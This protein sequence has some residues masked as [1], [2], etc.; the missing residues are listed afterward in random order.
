M[1]SRFSV[2]EEETNKA[3]TKN[4]VAVLVGGALILSVAIGGHAGELRFQ[5]VMNIGTHGNEPGRFAYV[6]DF[7]FSKDGR[8][9]VTDAANSN[10]QVF[11][12]TSGQY[13]TQFGGK[14]DGDEYLEKPEG[15]AVWGKKGAGNGEF[16][17]LHGII[18]DQETGWVYV[19]DTANNR[20]QVFKPASGGKEMN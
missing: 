19:A 18:V 6:E 1:I 17:N 9:L 3:Q 5:L 20:I 8:L 4:G 10:V 16:D 7:A 11:D 14:G 2:F 13:I 15:I 12:K